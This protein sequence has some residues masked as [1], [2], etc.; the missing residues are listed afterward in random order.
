MSTHTFYDGFLLPT[1]WFFLFQKWE[2]TFGKTKEIQKVIEDLQGVA[3]PLCIIAVRTPSNAKFMK[4]ASPL[5]RDLSPTLEITDSSKIYG[6]LW[7]LENGLFI[8]TFQVRST[9]FN[10][11]E[12][13]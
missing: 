7:R 10:E 5:N 4:A 3:L 9:F 6:P 1:G 13:S 11:T 8:T 2:I 12:T